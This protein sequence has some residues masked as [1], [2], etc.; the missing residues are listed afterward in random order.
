MDVL[1][2]VYVVYAS[3]VYLISS[4]CKAITILYLKQYMHL[5]LDDRG[6]LIDWATVGAATGEE[7]GVSISEWKGPEVVGALWVFNFI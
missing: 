6:E 1:I 5:I 2:V 3:R 7:Q 4:F